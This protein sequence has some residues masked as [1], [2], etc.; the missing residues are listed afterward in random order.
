ML[1]KIAVEPA[2]QAAKQPFVTPSPF[3]LHSYS[4]QFA[5]VPGSRAWTSAAVSAGSDASGPAPGSGAEA[6]QASERGRLSVAS[7][8]AHIMV[9][10]RGYN[11]G[12]RAV[13]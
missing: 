7:E 4:S 10:G 13:I 3:A 1:H 6:V 5:H 9:A 2:W 12:A 8:R 11:I